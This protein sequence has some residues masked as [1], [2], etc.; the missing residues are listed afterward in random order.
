MPTAGLSII[1][2]LYHIQFELEEFLKKDDLDADERKRARQRLKEFKQLIVKADPAYLGGEE[3]YEHL[4]DIR[5]Q[6]NEKTKSSTRARRV[7]AKKK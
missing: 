1:H 4:C 5:D 6:V 2:D 7:V 3:V